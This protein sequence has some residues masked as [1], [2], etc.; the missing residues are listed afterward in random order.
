MIKKKR[1]LSLF[2]AGVLCLGIIQ[3]VQADDIDDAKKK[4]ETLE[5][6]KEQAEKEQAE[7]SAKLDEI[8]GDMQKTQQDLSD[9]EQEINVAETELVEAKANENDQYE[10]M[11]LRIKY[12]YENNNTELIEV[13]VSAKSMSDLL[14]K[15]EYI[16]QVTEYDRNMLKEYQKTREDIEKKEAALKVE[17]A[18]LETLRDELQDDQT[19]IQALLDEKNIQIDEL[20]SKIS[21]NAEELKKL[22]AEAKAAEERR[23][24]QQNQ[25]NA[26][27]PNGGSS[28][29]V[30]TG[31]GK[32]S[33]P[34]PGARITSGFGYRDA[35]TA[36]ATS[37]HDGID[38][39]ASSG[40]PIYAADSGTVI[41]AQYNSAR[42]YYIVINHGN[43][44][45]TW[46]QHCSALYVSVGD[47]VSRGQNIAAVGMTGIST[48]PHLHFEVHVNGTPV[49]PLLYL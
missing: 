23:K 15:I 24:Q 48:G 5:A 4:Q 16:Q 42:G 1:L 26:Y 45:Q 40:T 47:K 10:S 2:L 11:K 35:P 41:T 28:E 13:L 38:Y 8:M 25:A 49:N 3:P 12:M 17:Y 27:K 19:Q 46:Y 36:G 29:I 21:A 37:K 14:N 30:I 22:I 18:E 33:H 44:M 9:K 39:G 32:L 20:A 43:G 31:N 7:L 34:I 6:Q